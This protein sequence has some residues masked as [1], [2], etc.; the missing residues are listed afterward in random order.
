MH[1]APNPS[2]PFTPKIKKAVQT[3]WS[4]FENLSMAVSQTPP[5]PEVVEPRPRRWPYAKTKSRGPVHFDPERFGPHLPFHPACKCKMGSGILKG[6]CDRR[7][8]M[9]RRQARSATFQACPVSDVRIYDRKKIIGVPRKSMSYDR[10]ILQTSP[11]VKKSRLQR[12]VAFT[13]D[14]ATIHEFVPEPTQTYCKAYA[15]DVILLEGPGSI[16]N[17]VDELDFRRLGRLQS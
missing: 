11:R 10:S 9:P 15:D 2:I 8:G 5:E 17:A 12:N 1:V 3:T 13:Q 7:C 4:M 14:L 16:L 6:M